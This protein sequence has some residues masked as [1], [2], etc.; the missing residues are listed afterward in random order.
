MQAGA[1]IRRG[2][3]MGC[4]LFGGSDIGMVFQQQDAHIDPPAV[5]RPPTEDVITFPPF[6]YSRRYCRWLPIE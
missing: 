1:G 6:L 3:P 5:I 4:F 2:D